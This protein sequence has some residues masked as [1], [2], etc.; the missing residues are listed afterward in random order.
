LDW[1]GKKNEATLSGD[2]QATAAVATQFD[3]VIH[4]LLAVRR[5]AGADAPQDATTRLLGETVFGRPLAEEEIVSILRN[6]TV[7]E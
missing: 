4:E 3:D 1:V 7:G 5:R 6:W 2:R